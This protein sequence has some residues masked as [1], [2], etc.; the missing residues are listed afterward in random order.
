MGDFHKIENCL[1]AAKSLVVIYLCH[2]ITFYASTLVADG[3]YVDVEL[4][5]IKFPETLK[6]LKLFSGSLNGVM[7][8][9]NCFEKCSVDSNNKQQLED[10]ARD[11]LDTP[12]FRNIIDPTKSKTRLRYVKHT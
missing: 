7:N 6:E 9:L 1:R 4:E 11:T 5:T 2:S 8:V 10:M 3:M 12:S